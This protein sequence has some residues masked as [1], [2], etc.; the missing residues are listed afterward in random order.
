MNSHYLSTR[1]LSTHTLSTRTTKGF[2]LLELLIAIALSAVVAVISYSALDGITDADSQIESVT[3]QINDI[4][5]TLRLLKE[6]LAHTLPRVIISADGSVQPAFLA[7]NTETT[8]SKQAGTLTGNLLTLTRSG[9]LNPRLA[10]RSEQQRVSY[11]LQNQTLSRTHRKYLDGIT[12]Q[13]L[14]TIDLLDGV[15]SLSLRFLDNS[16]KQ[17]HPDSKYWKN[18]WPVGASALTVS[19]SLP[20]AVQLTIDVEGF[21]EIRRIFPLPEPS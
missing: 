16:A 14:F 18:Q 11:N 4:D 12:E 6:D 7:A 21:G 13:P 1:T 17:Y 9:W 3:E 10:E 2:T 19:E 5:R 8:A 20:A 15:R